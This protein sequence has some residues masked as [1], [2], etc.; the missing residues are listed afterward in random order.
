[1]KLFTALFACFFSGLLVAAPIHNIVIFGDSLSDNG[2]LYE[3]M[4]HKLPPSPPYFEG[5]FSNGLVWN[6]LLAARYFSD[7]QKHLQNY[8]LGGAGVSEDPDDFELLTLTKE[9][10]NYFTAHEDQASAD[11]LY[12]VWIGGNNYLANPPNADE[13]IQ[14]VN[15]G[16]KI[17]MQ[18]LVE[19]GAKNIAIFNLPNLGSTPLAAEFDMVD[20]FTYFSEQNN[21]QLTTTFES[22]QQ[23]YPQVNWWYIDLGQVFSEVLQNAADYGFTNTTGY[24]YDSL[25][26]SITKNTVLDM[27]VGT[28]AQKGI[29]NCEGYLFFDLVHPTALAHQVIADKVHGLLEN[30]G[31]EIG[32]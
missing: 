16:I 30:A 28:K 25:T 8:A 27:V 2:N 12:V 18:R 4:D 23:S 15:D 9:I 3:M 14:R 17:G 22:L 21:K 26:K 5:R 6:E 20:R 13:E 32:D 11:S 24:C 10:E 29:S 1:M 19:H 31:I 7:P